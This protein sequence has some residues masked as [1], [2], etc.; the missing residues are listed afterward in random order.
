MKCLG[1][2]VVFTVFEGL[3]STQVLRDVSKN[4]QRGGSGMP[5]I[6]TIKVTFSNVKLAYSYIKLDQS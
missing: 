2:G 3:V 1:P 6:G 4:T 5:Q